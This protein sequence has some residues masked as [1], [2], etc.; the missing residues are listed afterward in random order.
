MN[1]GEP[2]ENWGPCLLS[3]SLT[4][5]LSSFPTVGKPYI[6]PLGMGPWWTPRLQAHDLT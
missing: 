1:E 3:R 4:P 6:N 5:P 2:G